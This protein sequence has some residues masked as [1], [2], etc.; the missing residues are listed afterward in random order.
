M[1]PTLTFTSIPQEKIVTWTGLLKKKKK[2]MKFR[3]TLF[4]KKEWI[5]VGI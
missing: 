1:D 3:V 5:W 4:P 2:L